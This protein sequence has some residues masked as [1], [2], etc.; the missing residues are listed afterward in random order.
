MATIGDIIYSILSNDTATNAIVS[1][2]IAPAPADEDEVFPMIAYDI[3]GTDL[4][5]TGGGI[6]NPIGVEVQIASIALS[7]SAALAL[8]TAVYKALDAIKNVT[9]SG[10]LVQG[11]VLKDLNRTVEVLTQEKQANVCEVT[12]VIWFNQ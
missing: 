10:T 5:E 1:N 8:A 3:Q 12:C 9:V 2:R 11:I 6:N 4:N 7:Q